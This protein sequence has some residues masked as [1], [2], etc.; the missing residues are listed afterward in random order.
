MEANEI[1]A[2]DELARSNCVI[3][4]CPASPFVLFCDICFVNVNGDI[5][6]RFYMATAAITVNVTGTLGKWGLHGEV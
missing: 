2:A 1:R 6:F 3:F 4:H 5:F